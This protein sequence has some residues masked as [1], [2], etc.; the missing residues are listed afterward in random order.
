M[1]YTI[2]STCGNLKKDCQ[3]V[4]YTVSDADPPGWPMGGEK[5]RVFCKC[6]FIYIY[7]MCRYIYIH[8]CM[9]ICYIYIY[10]HI[11]L[12]IYMC[13]CLCIYM[14]NFSAPLSNTV[15]RLRIPSARP[16]LKSR[17][18]SRWG[19]FRN[20]PTGMESFRTSGLIQLGKSSVSLHQ[21]HL[22]LKGDHVFLT[23]SSVIF[24]MSTEPGMLRVCWIMFHAT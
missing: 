10:T 9:C 1:K 12:Y 14:C 2:N 13:V 8:I 21:Q 6:V 22:E 16:L 4:L 3:R 7:I 17:C 23:L 18:W 24:V 19:T 11:L 15:R 20:H 5:E